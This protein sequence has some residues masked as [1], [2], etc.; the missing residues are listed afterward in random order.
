LSETFIFFFFL[1]TFLKAS[2]RRRELDHPRQDVSKFCL[3]SATL[4][5]VSFVTE[6]DVGRISYSETP[7][8]LRM[9]GKPN[10][11]QKV[12]DNGN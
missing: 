12:Y 10:N 2:A 7:N 9:L 1:I 3:L 5:C 6:I 4:H 8:T 11:S